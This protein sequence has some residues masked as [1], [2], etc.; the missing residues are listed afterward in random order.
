MTWPGLDGN[1]NGWIAAA[2]MATS[3]VYWIIAC[4]VSTWALRERD[5]ALGRAALAINAQAILV[6]VVTVFRTD[7]RWVP[8]WMG[9]ENHWHVA[10]V[11]WA[12]ALTLAAW[13]VGFVV[14][15]RQARRGK[16]D[17]A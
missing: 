14:A 12:V 6:V 8:D 5:W 10:L 17:V 2:Y 13:F 1:W 15:R 16:V 7:P 3:G 11:V 4:I 9:D